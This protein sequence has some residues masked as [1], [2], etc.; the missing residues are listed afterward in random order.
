MRPEPAH[1]KYTMAAPGAFRRLGAT[2]RAVLV[3]LPPSETKRGGGDGPPLRLDLLAH[4]EL[5]PLRAEL[6]DELVEARRRRRRP[7]GPRWGCRRS[8]TRRWR[9]TRSCGRRRPCPRCT[10]TPGCSTTRSTSARCGARPRCGPGAGW[11]SAR[12][13]S[14]CSRRTTRCPPTGCPRARRCPGAARSPRRWRPV[15]EPVLAAVAAREL[16]VDLRSGSYAALARVPGA[17]TVTVRTAGGRDRQPLQ[18]GAQGPARAG[19]WPCTRAEPTDAAAWR[20][21]PGGRAWHVD[22]RGQRPDRGPAPGV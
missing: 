20:R 12:R 7:P 2:V 22:R 14:G 19:C 6:L 15:L 1:N 3:L 21:S 17:V 13:C 9:A 10:A 16:V 11:S 4:P 18:Q 5:N 8:R